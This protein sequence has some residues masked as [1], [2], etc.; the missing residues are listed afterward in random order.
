M[1]IVYGA[2]SAAIH[3]A[4]QTGANSGA[5][6]WGQVSIHLFDVLPQAV[7]NTEVVYAAP[8]PEPPVGQQVTP[9][10]RDDWWKWAV[11][12]GVVSLAAYGI[13][14]LVTERSR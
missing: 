1:N 2:P 12:A 4:A 10:Q 14:K 3:E 7:P 6:D 5:F 11:G 13:Y 8:S 9:E